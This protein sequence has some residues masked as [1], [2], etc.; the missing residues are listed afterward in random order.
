VVSGFEQAVNSCRK[1]KNQLENS[2]S[3]SIAQPPLFCK[4][5]I[6]MEQKNQQII[7]S[8]GAAAPNRFPLDFK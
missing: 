5:R 8:K 4:R 2:T 1:P 7:L 3:K 6:K